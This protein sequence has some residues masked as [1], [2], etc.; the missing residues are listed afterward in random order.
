MLANLVIYFEFL[1][2][3]WQIYLSIVYLYNHVADYSNKMKKI[4]SKLHKSSS[5]TPFIKKALY[6]N[7]TPTFAKVKGKF[8]N[9]N[10]KLNAEKDLSKS[11]LNKHFNT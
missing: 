3:K 2:L 11:H 8:L 4:L 9:G 10:V 1:L 6:Q 5:S 7:V